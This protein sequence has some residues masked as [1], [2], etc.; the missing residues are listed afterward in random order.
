MMFKSDFEKQQEELDRAFRVE[1]LVFLAL[2]LMVVLCLFLGGCG[3][4]SPDDS[5]SPE[6][7]RCPWAA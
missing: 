5:D 1:G 3:G 4:G 2:G 6:K 7:T